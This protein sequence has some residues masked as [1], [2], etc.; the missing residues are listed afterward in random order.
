[1][2]FGYA[3]WCMNRQQVGACENGGGGKGGWRV[4]KGEGRRDG[5]TWLTIH[6]RKRL[7]ANAPRYTKSAPRELECI[8]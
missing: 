2:R 4:E 3:N 5:V 6:Y 8:Q 1:M 7:I